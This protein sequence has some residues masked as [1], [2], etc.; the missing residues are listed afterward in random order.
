MPRKTFPPPP[1]GS[2]PQEQVLQAMQD[3]GFL[4]SAV[5]LLAMI[6]PQT[7]KPPEWEPWSVQREAELA[8]AAAMRG[9]SRKPAENKMR[10]TPGPI[11]AKTAKKIAAKREKLTDKIGY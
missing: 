2:I 11:K 5:A 8:K 7:G 9:E 4:A 10:E 1:A 6:R 3:P